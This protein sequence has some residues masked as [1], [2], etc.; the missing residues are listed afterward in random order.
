VTA[1]AADVLRLLAEAL[2]DDA[3][4][5]WAAVM[6]LPPGTVDARLVHMALAATNSAKALSDELGR[7]AALAEEPR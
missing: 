1:P 5:V 2:A 7:R 4:R 3:R 6:A